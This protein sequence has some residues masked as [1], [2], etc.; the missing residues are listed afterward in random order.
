MKKMFLA[1]PI[2]VFFLLFG[3]KNNIFASDWAVNSSTGLNA[4]IASAAASGDS[5]TLNSDITISSNITN[6][7]NK[8]LLFTTDGSR[9]ILSAAGLFSGFNINNSTVSVNNITFAQFKTSAAGGAIYNNGTVMLDYVTFINNSAS[10]GGAVYNAANAVFSST[11]GVVFS[12]NNATTALAGYGGGAI[13][14]LGTA[15]LDFV[16]FE[17]NISS[18]N[19]GAVYNNTNAVFLSTGVV[20]TSNTANG[21]VVQQDGGGAIY[22]IGT[23]EILSG[24]FLWNTAFNGGAIYNRNGIASIS[25]SLFENN[26]TFA[27]VANNGG[28]AIANYAGGVLNIS[29]STFTHNTA[30]N[31]GAIYING[32]ASILN[33]NNSAFTSNTA[34][35]SSGVNGGGA[36]C[37]NAGKINISGNNSFTNNSGRY[38]GAILLFSSQAA[39]T[40]NT[41]SY[42][43]F[44]SNVSTNRGGAIY[45]EGQITIASATFINNTAPE[46][47]AVLNNINSGISVFNI[48]GNVSFISNTATSGGAVY[49]VG[50]GTYGA[51]FNINGN[52]L[53]S[54]NSASNGGAIYNAANSTVKMSAGNFVLFEHNTA[55]GTAGGGAVYNSGRV[56]LDSATFNNNTATNGGAVYNNGSSAILNVNDAVFKNNSAA[57]NGGAIYNT[58]NSNVTAS[59][60]LFEHNTATG[61]AGGGAIYNSGRVTLDSATFNN[62]SSSVRGGAVYN[63]TNAVFISTGAVFSSNTAAG[64]TSMQNGGGAIYNAGQS[65]I[66][67]NS[68]SWNTAFSGGAIFNRGGSRVV[69]VSDSFFTRNSASANISHNGGGAIAN[70]AAGIVNVSFSTFT[71][72]SAFNGG[73]LYNH[74]ANSTLNLNNVALL[75]NTATSVSAANGGGALCNT[76]AIVNI[77]GNNL[78]TFN[79][80]KSAGGAILNYGSTALITIDSVSYISFKT[81]KSAG[82]GG[83][84]SNAAGTI[85]I[86]GVVVFDSNAAGTNGGAIYNAANS[87]VTTSIGSSLLFERNTAVTGGAIHNTGMVMIDSA[88]FKNNAAANGGAIYNVSSGSITIVSGL[89]ENNQT[90]RTPTS[91]GGAIVNYGEMTIN[92]GIFTGNLTSRYGGAIYNAGIMNLDA[93]GGDIILSKGVTANIGDNDIYNIATIN[94]SGANDVEV[95]SRINGNGMINKSNAGRFLINGNSSGFNGLFN[96]TGGTTIVTSNY[97]TGVSSITAGVLELSTGTVLSTGTIGIYGSGDMEITTSGDLAFTGT[98]AG[99]GTINN[100]STGTFTL[101]GNNSGFTGVYTQTAGTTTVTNSGHMFTGTNT[102]INSVLNV[103]H[104]GTSMGYNVNIGTNGISNYYKTDLAVTNIST[105]NINFTGDDGLAYFGADSSL[106]SYAKYDLAGAFNDIG[107]GNK[108]I[109]DNAAVTFTGTDF[110]GN[111]LYGFNNSNVSIMNEL[112][113]SSTRTVEFGSLSV[114][115]TK[116]DFGVVFEGNVA[117]N[118]MLKTS[119]SVGN[120]DLGTLKIKHD[121]DAGLNITHRLH[122]LDGIEFNSGSGANIATLVYEYEVKV[123]TSSREYVVLTATKAT[124]AYSLDRM[125]MKYDTRAFIFSC[126]GAYQEGNSLHRMSS[127]TFN[128]LGYSSNAEDSVLSGELFYGTNTITGRGAFFNI[129]SGTDVEFNLK[130]LRVSSAQANGYN[131]S[132]PTIGRTDIDGSA[133]RIMSD[134]ATVN[135]TNVIFAENQAFGKGG[136]IYTGAGALNISNAVFKNNTAVSGGAIYSDN[137]QIH[138]DSIVFASNTATAGDGGAVYAA[139]NTFNFT[140]AS[141]F[142]NNKAVNGNGGGAYFWKAVSIFDDIARFISNSAS[143]NGGAVYADNG[144][145]VT[146][147]DNVYFENNSAGNFGGALYVGSGTV[148]NMG[149]I[150]FKNNT[151]GQKGGAVYMEGGSISDLA[152]LSINSSTDTLISGNKAAGVSN[153]FHLEKYAELNLDIASGTVMDIRDAMTVTNNNNNVITKEGDGLLALDNVNNVLNGRLNIYN[154]EIRTGSVTGTDDI[155]FRNGLL[156]LTRSSTL[157]RNIYVDSPI[158]AVSIET[159]SNTV[160]TYNGAMGTGI[161]GDFN[162]SGYGKIIFNT[163]SSANIA[164]TMVSEGELEILTNNFLSLNTTIDNGA[165]LTGNGTITGNVINSGTL[166]PGTT[167][168]F[169]TL[170]I[171]GDYTENGVL[172]VRLNENINPTND[173]LAVTGNTV[174]N[175]GSKVNLDL[176]SGFILNTSYVILKSSGAVTGNYDGLLNTLPSFGI[177]VTTD[178]NNVYLEVTSININYSNTPGMS[179]NQKETAKTIDAISRGGNAAILAISKIIGTVDPLS[180]EGKKAVFDEIAGSVYANA[181]MTAAKNSGRRQIFGQIEEKINRNPSR[182]EHS[183]CTYNIWSQIYGSHINMDSDSNSPKNF[184]DSSGYLMVGFDDY[185]GDLNAILGYTAAF[186]RHSGKQGSDEL[187]INDYKAGA[188]FGAFGSKWTFKAS[189]TSGYQ[190]YEAER[191]QRILQS[192]T[193]AEYDGYTLTADVDMYYSV[194][195]KNGFKLSPF[196]GL[197]G[198]YIFTNEFKEKAKG[199]AAVQLNVKENGF[200][201]ADSRLGLRVEN[202]GQ[203]VNWY[204]ELSGKY[205]LTGRKGMFEAALNGLDYEMEIYG[206]SN[207]MFSGQIEGGVNVKLGTHVNLFVTGAL[208]QA[209]RFGIYS[210]QLGINYSW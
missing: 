197:E 83:A 117:G 6:I 121:N 193:S 50:S 72:N 76:D 176:R 33:F 160:I 172:A 179:H 202:A 209:E 66:F 110:T 183:P 78:F 116:L 165:F 198:S 84:I 200:T 45:N 41:D 25:D 123:D 69:S 105:T 159:D 93:V 196:G 95:N 58:A 40:A 111:T 178:T 126:G 114:S 138:F 64:T 173:I 17:N 152:V 168:A 143:V 20:F 107:T 24:S 75:S 151:A 153:V 189:A 15:A 86:D 18:K 135:V 94:I 191:Q 26:I 181:L 14:N 68:F 9:R 190:Q 102:I 182:E 208:E 146:Y 133:I 28:G 35:A 201:T 142:S 206:A 42:I 109:F 167:S 175:S 19:G 53:F 122:V 131:T 2:I 63:N 3:F 82:F 118:D 67:L 205:N 119:S 108:V 188:Y 5:I 163:H 16:T 27:D 166:R 112:P 101:T 49:S 177:A 115:N 62:N 169:G 170:T 59:T 54:S 155:Y 96:Q 103:V 156:H 148:V 89:F 134:L 194:Y 192:E 74:D 1:V 70:Y 210:G 136:A 90:T 48:N 4:G 55:T 97:F 149:N 140:G 98:I 157:D 71:F 139:N 186:G 65:E 7:T 10:R 203:L 150:E 158:S 120:F 87:T 154:G 92:S 85:N 137:G 30:F 81:N 34:T 141:P 113:G 106:S 47:G 204:A 174:I 91:D 129:E 32:A 80:A 145:S 73:A 8:S 44:D 39:I 199:N 127:G 46:G 104:N 60:V 128:V 29:F 185:C 23:V 207:S 147:N 21:T 125:N 52:V 61:T 12:A 51:D 36:I 195:Q 56:T 11:G 164:N 184:T 77:T 57:A 144:S 161:A 162:K 38:G 88:T 79:E 31:G 100:I 180:D 99:D 43:L 22:N 130:D 124:N 13:Y 37:S 132:D 171:D 187:T